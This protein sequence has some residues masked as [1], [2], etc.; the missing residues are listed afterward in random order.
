MLKCILC[1]GLVLWKQWKLYIELILLLYVPL[2]MKPPL[3][4]LLKEYFSKC[5]STVL[6]QF[7][8]C[9][10]TCKLCFFVESDNDKV[11]YKQP[12]SASVKS[13]ITEDIVLNLDGFEGNFIDSSHSVNEGENGVEVKYYAQQKDILTTLMPNYVNKIV[14][15]LE[16]CF[17]DSE[18]IEKK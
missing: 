18:I 17:Q 16:N 1:I 14:E 15:N 10:W 11:I 3:T 4:L 8:T 2:N 5:L 7:L 13:V 6:S 12:V 9:W